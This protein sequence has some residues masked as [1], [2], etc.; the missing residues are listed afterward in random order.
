MKVLG[1]TL[2]LCLSLSCS[3]S[4]EVH[5]PKRQLPLSHSVINQG[6]NVSITRDPEIERMINKHYLTEFFE[7]L[8]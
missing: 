8:T 3:Y 6:E 2:V 1:S 7:E 5:R 4:F